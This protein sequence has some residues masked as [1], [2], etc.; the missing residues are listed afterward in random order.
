MIEFHNDRL[1]PPE[2][3]RLLH[4]VVPQRHHVPVRFFNRHDAYGMPTRGKRR[5]Y[6]TEFGIFMHDKRPWIGINLNALYYTAT[7]YLHP[8]L[9]RSTAVWRTLVDVCLHEFGHAATR[10]VTERLNQHEYDAEPCGRVYRYMEQLADG[11]KDARLA[12]ILRCDARLGQPRCIAGYLSVRLAQQRTRYRKWLSEP[13]KVWD[14]GSVRA[15]YF[16]EQR[17]WRTG[18]QLSAGD[19][20][21][22]LGLNPCMFTNAYRVLRRA[23]DGL[24]VD[25]TDGAGRRHKLYTWGDVPMLAERLATCGEELVRRSDSFK[26][27]DIPAIPIVR[28][29]SDIQLSEDDYEFIPF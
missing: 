18:A 8:R 20:L 26:V 25:Y 28:D 19:V 11:W 6:S 9:A 22:E 1:V 5:G 2:L 12:Q 21:R 16:K 23:S 3:C 14:I 4:Q 7:P 10:D 24:G 17:C 13:G 15:A 27:P 29:A